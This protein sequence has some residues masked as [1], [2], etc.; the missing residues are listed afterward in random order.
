MYTELLDRLK[1]S[2]KATCYRNILIAENEKLRLLED[3]IENPL[4]I[5]YY[6]KFLIK[7]YPEQLF[8]LCY[9]VIL[10]NCARAVN[11]S[12]YKKVTK[13][14]LQLIKWNGQTTAKN[15]VNELKTLYPRKTALI[16]ELKTVE[17][18]LVIHNIETE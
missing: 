16:D 5:F 10:D 17:M 9:K 11:R 15:I 18:K 8:A 7:D 4:E 13:Q 3:V 6:G 2:K 12:D 1:E 14:I